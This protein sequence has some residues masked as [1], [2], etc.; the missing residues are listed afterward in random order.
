M[1]GG[2]GEGDVQ[3]DGRDAEADLPTEEQE[4]E[5]GQTAQAVAPGE[6]GPEDAEARDGPGDGAVGDVDAG[7]VLEQVAP[8]AE[9]EII[10][11]AA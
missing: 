3:D 4:D 1:G 9:L 10:R 7:G 2:G 8:E 6:G 11:Y 5:A